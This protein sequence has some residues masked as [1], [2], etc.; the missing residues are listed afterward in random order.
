VAALVVFGTVVYYLVPVPGR[1][2]ESSWAI[3]F[4]CGV[5]T[6]GLLIAFAIRRLLG[7]GENIRVRGLVLLLVLS[8]LFFAWCDYSV[9]QL[10]GQFDDLRTKTDG[11]Y[12][13]VST[14]ATVGFGD[15]HAVGQLARAA[16]TV[17]MVFHL[18]FL[19]AAVA[20]ISG[21]LKERARRRMGGPHHDDASPVPEDRD[22][23]S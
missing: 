18:V 21:F 17:Q 13:T 10:P 20:I 19:G 22:G 16:V 6:L 14:I 2:R 12:F 8:V 1:M 3:L 9:A 7:A 11:L 23:A 4:S 15:V 5:V